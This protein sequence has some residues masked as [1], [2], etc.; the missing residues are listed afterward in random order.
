MS[1]EVKFRAWNKETKQMVDLNKITPLALDIDP[2]LVGAGFGVYVPDD[3]RLEI[4][5]FTGLKDKNGTGDDI[6][7]GS[8]LYRG[9]GELY[10]VVWR[11]LHGQWWL[12]E[13]TAANKLGGW[14]VPLL[15][16]AARD[17]LVLHGSIHDNP[18]LLKG[19][20]Q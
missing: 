6:Y 10:A 16:D 9:D 3:P 7:A 4:M 20:S 2:T 12:R 18:E 17:Y 8:L 11:K 1:R 15:P 19:V 14:A 13:W 5:Q